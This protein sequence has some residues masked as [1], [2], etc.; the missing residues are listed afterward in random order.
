MVHGG[1]YS[2]VEGAHEVQHLP[3]SYRTCDCTQPFMRESSYIRLAY[4]MSARD[5]GWFSYRR[6]IVVVVHLE[7]PAPQGFG[8]CLWLADLGCVGLVK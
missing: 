4:S 7:H 2:E 1:I 5:L 3:F 6:K 8:T